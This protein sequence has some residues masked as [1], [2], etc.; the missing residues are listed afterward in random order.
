ML[1]DDL[2]TSVVKVQRPH[3]LIDILAH[4]SISTGFK[5][6]D[7]AVGVAVFDNVVHG[8]IEVQEYGDEFLKLCLVLGVVHGSKLES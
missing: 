7:D 4:K 5:P 8:K 6:H 1:P 3:V 2:L